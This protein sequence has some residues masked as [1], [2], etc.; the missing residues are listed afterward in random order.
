MPESIRFEVML[1][2]IFSW[3]LCLCFVGQFL[4]FAPGTLGQRTRDIL[5][6]DLL[7][8]KP[9]QPDPAS[10]STPAKP[11]LP[12]M[13]SSGSILFPSSPG[14]TTAVP[15]GLPGGGNLTPP[16]LGGGGNVR[17]EW[18]KLFL[19]NDSPTLS[20]PL[21]ISTPTQPSESPKTPSTGQSD[22]FESVLEVETEDERSVRLLN[23]RRQQAGQ[24]T[25]PERRQEEL[26]RIQ[27]DETNFQNQLARRQKDEV[28]TE[29]TLFYFPRL[30]EQWLKNGWCQLFDGHTDFGWK[31]QTEGNYAG[32]WEGGKFTFGQG[33]IYSDPR[34]PGLIYS[35]IP[36]GDI[37]VRVDYWA[38]KDSRIFLLLKTP[39][40]PTDLNKSCYTVVL[41]SD[42]PDRP[43]GL[44]IGRHNHSRN[45]LSISRNTWDDPLN[46]EQ[47]TW[48]SVTVKNEEN[49]IQIWLDKRPPVSYFVENPLRSGHVALL[50]TKGKARFQ[51]VLW[52]PTQSIAM[53]ESDPPMERPW[54]LSE[55][56]ELIGNNEAGFSLLVGNVESKE[57][58]ANYVL[59]MQYRQ[60][61][62][63]GKSS[64]WVRSLPEK[65]NS[66]YEISLQ[67]VPRR[68]DR[69]TVRGVDAGGFLQMMDARYIRP[70]DQQWTYFTMIAMDR[71]IHTWVNGVPVCEIYD[72]RGKKDVFSAPFLDPGTIRLSVPKDNDQFQ[73][74]HLTVSPM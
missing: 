61:D 46:S 20:L 62:N 28:G 60:G 51:N 40:D 10:T 34:F 5:D 21:N 4:F 14:Q 71:K 68:S 42:Q 43:R 11:G 54:Q 49:Y 9:A 41:N 30:K 19:G 23:E 50:V 2:F 15:P 7:P 39:P 12:S 25:D 73:F 6:M 63:S 26:E 56:G 64:L 27:Q 22:K 1:R 37:N 3:S 65:E 67:N 18:E 35:Q 32:P 55:G 24:I 57:V 38:E 53:F 47:G 8:Q 31:I 17:G 29:D 74:R 16:P 59:Q 70:L 58:F 13:P 44:L 36:F 33:E 66:G 52:R 45:E 48:H 72:K 69:E